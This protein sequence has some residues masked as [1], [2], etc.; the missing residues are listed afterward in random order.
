[1][2][3]AEFAVDVLHH[4][5]R[6]VDDDAEIDG[7]NGEQIGGI[8]PSVQKNESEQQSQRNGQGRNQGGAHASQKEDEHDQH[9]QHPAHEIAFH[10]VGGDA[11]Q[12]AA[13]VVG[14]DFHVGRQD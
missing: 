12:V 14:T 2:P 3:R 6:A 8:A 9:Q 5:D 11:D 13:I 4:H 7:S 10:G 1:M